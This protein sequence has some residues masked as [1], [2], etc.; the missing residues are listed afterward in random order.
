M[1]I[2]KTKEYRSFQLSP[3]RQSIIYI[4][5]DSQKKKR[6]YDNVDVTGKKLLTSK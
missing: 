6:S 3:M 2:I 5:V 1:R 4:Y